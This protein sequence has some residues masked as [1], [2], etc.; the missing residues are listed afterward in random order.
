MKR[1]IAVALII[2]TSATGVLAASKWAPLTSI[3]PEPR[4][5]ETHFDP[6][7]RLKARFDAD[8]RP[9]PRFSGKT[10]SSS[11]LIV[12]EPDPQYALAS[13]RPVFRSPRPQSRPRGLETWKD[14]APKQKQVRMASVAPTAISARG[15]VCSDPK[16]EGER[17]TPVQGKLPGCRIQNPVRVQSVDGVRL[18]QQAILD[19]KTATTLRG[20]VSD[21]L[22]PVIGSKGGG[23]AE[24]KVPSHYSCR[25]RNSQKGAK[26]SEHAKGNAIDISAIVLKDG[27]SLTVLDGWKNRRERKI[28]SALHKGACGPF[29]TVLGPEANRF[30]VD[31]FHFDVASYRAGAYCE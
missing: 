27:S 11:D 1:A 10:P 30:H 18:S 15:T 7:P 8:I 26:L 25:T 4:A 21:T 17:L 14:S 3:R 9:R 13:T 28:L 6:K 22:K 23:V 2:L 5:P 19:C 16:I 24:L 31:H 12:P 29:G 20:W